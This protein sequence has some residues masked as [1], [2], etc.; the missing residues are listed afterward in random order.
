VAPEIERVAVVAATVV[1]A[2]HVEAAKPEVAARARGQTPEKKVVFG[3][4]AASIMKNPDRAAVGPN[5]DEIE[6]AG[7]KAEFF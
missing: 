4:K 3:G 6:A 7:A 5:A 1:A 2:K